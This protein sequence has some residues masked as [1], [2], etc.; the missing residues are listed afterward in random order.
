MILGG[1]ALT[2]FTDTNLLLAMQ[3]VDLVT[4]W[5]AAEKQLEVWGLFFRILLGD[6]AVQP[7]TY[8]VC[9]LAEETAYVG[10]QMSYALSG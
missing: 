3:R 2:S 4:N 10:A 9:S 8:D 5:E 7:T 6:A 1:G